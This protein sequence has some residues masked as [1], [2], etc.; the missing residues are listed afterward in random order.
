MKIHES[1]NAQK[2]ISIIV[3]TIAVFACSWLVFTIANF[4]GFSF[5]KLLIL[6][7]GVSFVFIILLNKKS[8]EFTISAMTA[9]KIL[10]DN[11]V[12][13]KRYVSYKN[14]ER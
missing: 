13:R 3:F 9:L 4:S 8:L 10:T 7:A 2:I 12:S 6:L 1:I 14:T 11:N 5:V